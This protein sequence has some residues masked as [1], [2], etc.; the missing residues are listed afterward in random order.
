MTKR[1]EMKFPAVLWRRRVYVGRPR[2]QDA[3]NAAFA[4]LSNLQKRKAYDRVA[5]GKENIIFGFAFHDGEDFK[6]SDMQD[7]RKRM[8]GFD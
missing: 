4:K 6:P 1:E 3:I 2:H 7:A 5:D 8:Y